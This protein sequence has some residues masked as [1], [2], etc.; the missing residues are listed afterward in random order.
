MP[1]GF[2]TKGQFSGLKLASDKA[3]GLGRCPSCDTIQKIRVNAGGHF[4]LY[5]P[6]QGGCGL[7]LQAQGF[8]A[9]VYLAGLAKGSGAGWYKG[10]AK[11]VKAII[12][13]GIPK[14]DLDEP[15]PE[16][17]LDHNGREMLREPAITE[18]EPV[19]EKPAPKPKKP[20]KKKPPKAPEP[21]TVKYP[22]PEPELD[23]GGIFEG[24]IF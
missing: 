16:P 1:R 2:G 15:E 4:Y 8:S 12:A 20:K 21:E 18:P 13:Q 24:G 22:E 14:P 5:C 10:N 9:N 3:A 19:P 11:A 23:G 6:P 17:D 7:K